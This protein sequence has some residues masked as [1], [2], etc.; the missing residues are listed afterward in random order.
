[1]RREETR[2][3]NALFKRNLRSARRIAL[4]VAASFGVVGF[5]WVFATDVLVYALFKDPVLLARIQTAKDWAFVAFASVALYD[6]ARRAA[7]WLARAHAVIT[8][9]VDSI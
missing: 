3:W 1:M 2:F 9:V 6:V 7:G 5:V 4:I 8:A